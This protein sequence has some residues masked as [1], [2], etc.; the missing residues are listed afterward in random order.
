ML[1]KISC[2]ICENLG[3]LLCESCARS[4]VPAPSLLPPTG[5]DCARAL[6]VYD[7]VGRK[8]VLALKYRNAHTLGS[9]L[10]KPLAGLAPEGIE[11]VTW[12]PSTRGNRIR[13]GY[14]QGEV[15]AR[16]VARHL[17]KPSRSLLARGRDK[18]QSTRTRAE[19]AKGP[20][21]RLSHTPAGSVLIVDDVLT[22]GA[23]L[24]AA[25]ALLRTGGARSVSALTAAWTPPVRAGARRACAQR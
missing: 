19:R 6:F 2:V 12:V 3:V 21:L 16:A 18:P 15:L 20:N 5:I 24:S 7:E 14:D 8:A 17:R 22:T 23:T 9:C 4:L 25:A 10:A 13:R 11:Q 1:F